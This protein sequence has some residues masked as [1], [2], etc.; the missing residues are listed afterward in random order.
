MAQKLRQP[1]VKQLAVFDFI[2]KHIIDNGFPPTVREV[3]GSFGF[4]SP[5][6]AQLHINALI[7][8]GLLKKS[9]SKQRSIEISGFKPSED[10]KIPLLGTVRAGAPILAVEHIE[11]Y[12][13]IDKNLFKV[14]G[15]FALRIKGDSMIDAGIL[16]GDIALIAPDAEPRNGDIV[17]ALIGDE[18]TVKRFFLAKSIVRL[19]PENKDME[20]MV[21]P[22]E[23]VRIIGK[24]K[25]I[26][27]SL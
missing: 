12:V 25:G 16:E 10:S 13:N 6:S 2:K 7:K 26:M 18:A 14:E 27:R 23:D 17:V 21:F 8:K 4:A 24:V 15:G 3:A 19:V 11:D 22:A 9:P 20:P 5:L 1:T